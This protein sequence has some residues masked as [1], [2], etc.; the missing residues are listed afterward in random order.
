MDKNQVLRNLPKMSVLLEHDGIKELEKTY[1]YGFIKAALNFGVNTIRDELLTSKTGL[2]EGRTDEE[3]LANRIITMAN[4]FLADSFYNLRPVINA[5]GIVIHTNLGRAPLPPEALRRIVQISGG[6]SNLEYDLNEGKRG[7]RYTHIGDILRELTGAQD[8]IAVNNNAAAV[9][10]SLTALARGRE[11]IISR[12][13]M[14]EIGGSFRIPEVLSQSGAKL[15]EVG[16]TNRTHLKD[17]ENAIN[18]DTALI[19]KVHPSNYKIAGFTCEAD[20][21]EL[22]ELAEK[23]NLIFMKDLGSGAMVDLTP[24]GYPAEPTVTGTVKT[25]ADIVTFSGDKLLGG[26]QAGIIVG[27]EKLITKIKSHPLTRALRIDKLT[28]AALETVLWYYKTNQWQDIP[29]NKMLIKPIE[30]MKND[31]KILAEGLSAILLQKGEAQIVDDVSEA[32]GGS[33]PAH[34]MPSKAVSLCLKDYTPRQIF[35]KLRSGSPPIIGRIKKDN[36][37]MDVRTL[38]KEEIGKIIETVGKMV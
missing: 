18:D 22:K 28:L 3:G 37:L 11:V 10:L 36:F 17:Y 34:E 32:G 4:E 25:G 7:E 13:E 9:L 24:F 8:A 20:D 33:M 19:L 5:T 29:V 16:T 35:A 21:T 2:S 30:E 6:Y 14:V 1:P 31:A 23:H 12:G 27:D 15:V 26:P 38:S